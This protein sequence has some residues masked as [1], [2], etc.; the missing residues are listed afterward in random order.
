MRSA[1]IFAQRRAALAMPYVCRP[2]MLWPSLA[3]CEACYKE[4]FRGNESVPSTISATDDLSEQVERD[5]HVL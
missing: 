3:L 5:M 2:R 1:H 4:S